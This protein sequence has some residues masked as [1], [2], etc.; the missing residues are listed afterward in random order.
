MI[1][2]V[3]VDPADLDRLAGTYAFEIK[4][5]PN[6]GRNLRTLVREGT[7]LFFQGWGANREELYAQSATTFTS[8]HRRDPLLVHP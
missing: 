8:R 4:A 5:G 1:K 7:R 6:A 3:P 2:V